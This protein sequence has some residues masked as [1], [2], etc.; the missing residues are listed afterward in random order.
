MQR[1]KRTTTT[2]SC[3]IF[4][5][6]FPSTYHSCARLLQRTT[7][8]PD[9]NSGRCG[10]LP[11]MW[12]LWTHFP[13]V[14]TAT[15]TNGFRPTPQSRRAR[16]ARVTPP[17]LQLALCASW[18]N[19]RVSMVLGSR[20]TFRSTHCCVVPIPTAPIT[21][22]VSSHCD[23]CPLSSAVGHQSGWSICFLKLRNSESTVCRRS[24]RRH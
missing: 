5:R 16:T 3:C 11:G 10:W 2:R 19:M 21:V 12:M 8:N 23:T 20:R 14:T 4:P 22:C 13:H 7:M 15:V 18:T 24:C 1:G 9:E 17:F 6:A